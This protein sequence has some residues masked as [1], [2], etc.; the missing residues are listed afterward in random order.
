[1]GRNPRRL[2][3]L[4]QPAQ[5]PNNRSDGSKGV[6][7][8]LGDWWDEREKLEKGRGLIPDGGGSSVRKNVWG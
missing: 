3:E 4:V 1:L 6:V 8:A 5:G 7:G 2:P